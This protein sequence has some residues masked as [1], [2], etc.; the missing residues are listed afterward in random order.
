MKLL[1]NSSYGYQIL[2]RSGHTVT[3]YLNDEKIHCAINSKF[4]IKLN[5]VNHQLYEVEL[6]KAK[7]EHKEPVVVAFFDVNY[8]KQRMLELDYN[9]F[10]KFCDLNK[11]EDF[12]MDTD[13]L[14]LAPVE[15]EVTDCIRPEMKTE[16]DIMRSTNCDDCFAA[17][18]TG[19]IFPEHVARNTRIMTRQSRV[20]SKKNS[21]DWKR[22]VFVVKLIAATILPP[23]S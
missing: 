18:A 9:F 20:S 21:S 6:A 14:Y 12:E 11:F 2:D 22:C 10:D 17:D 8:A 19:I 4:F 1:A 23:T 16:W 13:F 15:Q 3:K 5:H 7:V